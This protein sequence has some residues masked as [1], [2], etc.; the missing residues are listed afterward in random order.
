MELKRSKPRRRAVV[1]LNYAAVIAILVLFAFGQYRDWNTSL[2]VAVIAIA[3]VALMSF[4]M[5]HVKTH[6]WWLVHT[7]A[8]NLDERQIQLTHESLR[9]SYGIFAIITLLVLLYLGIMHREDSML[10]VV[11]ASLLYLAHTLPA[12]VI[13]WIEKEV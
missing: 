3:A 4:L 10:M 1:V 8:E 11:F 6:L 7:K 13:A 5:L 12:S 2:V 9:Y